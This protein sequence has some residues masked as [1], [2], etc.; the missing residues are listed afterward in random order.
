MSNDIVGQ[1]AEVHFTVTVKRAETGKEETYEMV[2]T[3]NQN[4]KTE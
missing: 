4:N 1:P 3:I 2:G